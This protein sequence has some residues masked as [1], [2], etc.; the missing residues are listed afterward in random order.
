MGIAPRCPVFTSAP[1]TSSS[2][3]EGIGSAACSANIQKKN[4]V[5]V[6]DHELHSF[7]HIK[8]DSHRAIDDSFG[9]QP[10]AIGRGIAKTSV[11]PYIWILST[12]N[13][14]CPSQITFSHEDG[15]PFGCTD[16]LLPDAQRV[17]APRTK[18]GRELDADSGCEV[19]HRSCSMALG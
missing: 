11:C 3:I 7:V 17:P 5:P 4:R 9:K 14:G 12:H 2:G 15:V 13:A 1:Q 8:A 19:S 16:V 6:P 18:P 10:I